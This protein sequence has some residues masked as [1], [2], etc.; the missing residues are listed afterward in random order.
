MSKNIFVYALLFVFAAATGI[1]VGCLGQ[2]YDATVFTLHKIISI[3]A[4]VFATIFIRRRI[5]QK[6]I[7]PAVRVSIIILSASAVAL[8]ATGALMSLGIRDEIIRLAHAFAPVPAAAAI[9]SVNISFINKW[10][11]L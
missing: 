10:K 6:G 8:V 4:I 3:G 7:T 5:K 11:Q 2:P 9:V 1:I